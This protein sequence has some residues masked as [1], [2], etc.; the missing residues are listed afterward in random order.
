MTRWMLL[1]AL[2]AACAEPEPPI[3]SDDA[4]GRSRD[5]GTPSRDHDGGLPAADA[6]MVITPQCPAGAVF[7]ESFE[8]DA[9]DPTRWR[10]GGSPGGVVLDET[11]GADG[12]RSVHVRMGEAY[13]VTEPETLQLLVPIPAPDD[14]VYARWF[15]RFENLALP[16]YHPNFVHVV[17][18]DFRIDEWWEHQQLSFGSF[19]GSFSINHLGPE[20]DAALLWGGWDSDS[21][22]LGD[23][24]PGDEH[25]LIAGEWLC[26]EMMVFGDHQGQGD[27]S[28]DGEEV[29]VWINGME[30]EDLHAD[31]EAWRPWG[32]FERW[33]PGYDGSVWT[34]G[35]MGAYTAEATTDV[36]YDA[37][38]FSPA[39][40]GCG[41]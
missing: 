11:I 34:F 16:G 39:R 23:D 27:T 10:I 2:A 19:A 38:A 14:R 36:W 18:P 40:I 15:M 24:T 31:D 26:V 3:Q 6:A 25:G 29:R 41:D 5:A 35:I 32:E 28:H 17:G 4:G 20:L 7:C 33:S 22:W 8:A 37:I 9:I 30:I 12:T 21:P 1:V 13:G